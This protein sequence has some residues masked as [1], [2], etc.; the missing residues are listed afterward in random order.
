MNKKMTAKDTTCSQKTVLLL[1]VKAD[2]GFQPWYIHTP[3]NCYGSD[4]TTSM[5][6]KLPYLLTAEKS[7]SASF[8]Y[9]QTALK[10]E[11]K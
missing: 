7:L 9:N 1:L 5:L 6:K 11:E 10:L 3:P 2:V 8:V 4:I